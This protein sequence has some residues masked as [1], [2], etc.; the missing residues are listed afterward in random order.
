VS[1]NCLVC[2]HCDDAPAGSEALEISSIDAIRSEASTSLRGFTG[3]WPFFPFGISCSWCLHRDIR[4]LVEL[5]GAG[6]GLGTQASIPPKSRDVKE[7]KYQEAVA[8][9]GQ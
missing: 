3:P 9:T 2:G 1:A 6:A 4:A 8:K 7:M 5:L